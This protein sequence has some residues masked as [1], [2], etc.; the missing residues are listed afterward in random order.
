MLVLLAMGAGAVH[1]QAPATDSA[2]TAP[3][4]IAGAPLVNAGG[5]TVRT[6]AI[7]D[8]VRVVSGTGRYAGTISRITADTVVVG[9]RGREDAIARAEVT[10][11]ERFGGKTSRGRSI[12]IGAGAG[13]VSGG[14]LG[15]IGG[16]MAGRI[17]CTPSNQ[18]C[19]PGE[20]DATIQGALLA[21]GAILGSLVG[22]MLGPTFRREHWDHAEG[23]FPI[24]AGPSPTGGISAAVTLRF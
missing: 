22:A 20:H 2:L 6:L 24:E 15:A 16:R 19:T 5:R 18:P 12:L 4:V 17:R 14:V 7:G 21:E 23:A 1:A 8:T 11:L 9:A 13:L 3:S 10:Q